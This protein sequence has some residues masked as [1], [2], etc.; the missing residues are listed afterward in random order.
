MS[1]GRDV[2]AVLLSIR[3]AARPVRRHKRNL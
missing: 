3:K 1:E 2:L